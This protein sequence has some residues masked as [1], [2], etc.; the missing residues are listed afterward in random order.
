M[1]PGMEAITSYKYI[2]RKS[3]SKEPIIQ[4][5]RIAVRDVV[6]NWKMGLS[7]EEIPSIYPHLTLSQ[8][9]EALAFYQDHK[10]EIE[11]FIEK[12]R[13]PENLIGKSLS[14]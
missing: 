11:A 7:P 9:F 14:R 13:V 3:D 6:E 4:G 10:E 5:T 1:H 8:V 12:N 2:V